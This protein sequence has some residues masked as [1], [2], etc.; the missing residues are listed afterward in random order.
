MI[1]DAIRR[2]KHRRRASRALA[3]IEARGT[4]PARPH[5]LP[6]PL[7]VSLTSYAARFPTLRLTLMSLLRQD[8]RPDAVILWLSETDRDL[9]PAEIR[10]LPGLEIRACAD[11]RSYTKVVPT[12]CAFPDA[13]VV[14]ADDDVYYEASW[15]SG[16]VAAAASGAHVACHRAHRVAMLSPGQPAPY[17]DWQ[18]NIDTAEQGPL[19]FLTG[20]G[21]VIYAPGTLHPDTARPEIFTELAP[22]SDDVWLYWMH[23]LLGVEAQ[24]I[25][26]RR[27][28]LEWDG[29]QDS[30]LRQVNVTGGPGND[31]AVAAL[32]RRYGWP[33]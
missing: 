25:G 9:L 29:S 22:S 5:G 6:V 1:R 32:V 4:A 23:R 14:T 19:V 15:L 30:N 27:R 13:Y 7:V 11:L 17:A 8:V 12:L 3:E 18:R 24:K 26:G 33:V 16:L 10:A 31:R 20:V 2:S 21:G 28:I